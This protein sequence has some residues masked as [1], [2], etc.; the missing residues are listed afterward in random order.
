MILY[1][2]PIGIISKMH[3]CRSEEKLIS[4]FSKCRNAEVAERL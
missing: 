2:E 4:M 1:A 3:K